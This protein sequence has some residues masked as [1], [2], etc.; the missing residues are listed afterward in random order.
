M[1]DTP[2]ETPLGRFSLAAARALRDMTDHDGIIPLRSMMKARQTL[3]L[4]KITDPT[5]PPARLDFERGALQF[6]LELDGILAEGIHV[7][8]ADALQAQEST[9]HASP[10]RRS[11]HDEERD[12]DAGPE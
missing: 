6:I 7:A 1:N 9:P 5:T 3:A 8:Y 2:V 4:S 12:S 11:R 10:G